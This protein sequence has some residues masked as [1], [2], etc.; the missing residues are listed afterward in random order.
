MGSST[1]VL[2]KNQL[3]GV[4]TMH[5]EDPLDCDWYTDMRDEKADVDAVMYL[6]NLN[7]HG[8]RLQSR[9]VMREGAE[10]GINGRWFVRLFQ[11]HPLLPRSFIFHISQGKTYSGVINKGSKKSQPSFSL[12]KQITWYQS[13]I[14]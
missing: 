3:L 6:R 10:C 1:Q 13:T 8:K 7:G 4:D 14:N 12:R 11:R 2:A 5:E 9:F